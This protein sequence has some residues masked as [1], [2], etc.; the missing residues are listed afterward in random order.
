MDACNSGDRWPDQRCPSC[1]ESVVGP[2]EHHLER[3][4][5]RFKRSPKQADNGPCVCVVCRRDITHLDPSQRTAHVNRCLDGEVEEPLQEPVV[6]TPSRNGLFLLM[7][8]PLCERSFKTPEACKS[9][10]RQCSVQL[11]VSPKQVVEAI[12]LQQRYVQ[13]RMAAGLPLVRGRRHG[14]ARPAE[15]R[16][17]KRPRPLASVPKSKFQEDVQMA[18]ALSASLSTATTDRE[19]A[20]RRFRQLF[21]AG[22]HVGRRK[23]LVAKE[24]PVL[25]TRTDEERAKRTEEK[26][27][28]LLTQRVNG[29]ELGELSWCVKLRAVAGT[30][31]RLRELASKDA[32]LWGL[33]SQCEESCEAFYVCALCD[34]VTPSQVVPVGSRLL[35]LT[36]LPGRHISRAGDGISA[37]DP[38]HNLG[39]PEADTQ[40]QQRMLLS[41]LGSTMP[42]TVPRADDD[43]REEGLDGL[44]MGQGFLA[45]RDPEC[46]PSGA[47]EAPALRRLSKD[48]DSLVG[49]RRFC[50]LKVIT[51]EAQVVPAHRLILLT[52]CPALEKD[53]SRQ[54]DRTPVLDW[55]SRSKACVLAFLRYLYAGVL[56]VDDGDSELLLELR[57][58]ALR[59]ELD[60]LCEELKSCHPQ[61]EEGEEV[62]PDSS[63]ADILATLWEGEE[64]PPPAPPEEE[65]S[66][67][68]DAL[69][70]VYEFAASQRSR[71][72]MSQRESLGALQDTQLGLRSPC[73]GKASSAP[74]ALHVPNTATGFERTT[75][76]RASPI[77]STDLIASYATTV[78]VTSSPIRSEDHQHWTD[79]YRRESP[80]KES[81]GVS[82]QQ[83]AGATSAGSREEDGSSPDLFG[84]SRSSADDSDNM[85]EDVPERPRS[86][87]DDVNSEDNEGVWDSVWDGFDNEG[88]GVT[89]DMAVPSPVVA[90]TGG[91]VS[92]S[93]EESASGEDRP[94]EEE[95]PAEDPPFFRAQ[96]A[97]VPKTP[98]TG[99]ERQRP[100]VPSTPVTPLP[101][102]GAMRTPELAGH[103]NQFGVRRFPRKQAVNILHHIYEQT[104]P[105]VP[106]TPGRAPPAFSQDP[107]DSA[108]ARR[109]PSRWSSQPNG[110]PEEDYVPGR[111]SSSDEDHDCHGA[112]G[113]D[114]TLELKRFLGS[115]QLYETVLAYEPIDFEKLRE[116][117]REAGIKIS[118]KALMDFLDE[119]CITFTVPRPD[120]QRQKRRQANFK[121]RIKA[122]QARGRAP[123]VS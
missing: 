81:P 6:S 3:C 72:G 40:V 4:L 110:A 16:P 49:S 23:K 98:V 111:V 37:I 33:A 123:Q 108:N 15:P 28:H 116:D 93:D 106:E 19:D 54:P 35:S 121:A 89:A 87:A 92:C 66:D 43:G 88:L 12:R 55:T 117:V 71:G 70:T 69:D 41:A 42:H 50:D 86:G 78:P 45:Q 57:G 46:N 5:Q 25:L 79:V 104:H 51:R 24:T 67:G 90:K 85:E 39:A 113:S 14:G 26:I 96:P 22:H 9:H 100:A 7:D 52:R 112:E 119:Q 13:E 107:S 34:T 74:A 118:A 2:T 53:M 84:E 109:K 58:L 101:D 83:D 103:L 8:C 76:C 10:V 47:R 102:Y 63:L 68:E 56:E 38:S 60:D 61:G 80:S 105:L 31:R 30:S 64:G 75:T 27:A 97:E 62:D 77:K 36:Q 48:L 1:G 44:E 114:L 32:L 20:Q 115:G 73:T 94:A 65:P 59:Y 11:G 29:L 18:K 99:H 82:P 122:A 95:Y 91:G 17:A 120:K 21:T